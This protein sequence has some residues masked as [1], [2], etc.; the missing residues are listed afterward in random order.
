M[1]P[2]SLRALQRMA[3]PH[4]WHYFAGAFTSPLDAARYG[5]A[6]FYI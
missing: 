5:Y 6:R 3:Q 1:S 2:T 4:V